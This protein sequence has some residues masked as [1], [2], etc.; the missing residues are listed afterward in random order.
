MGHRRAMGFRYRPGSAMKKAEEWRSKA[1]L[2]G[3]TALLGAAVVVL[4]LVL[5]LSD[6]VWA[7]PGG[8]HTFSRS[9]RGS[10]GGSYGGW[11]G[12]GGGGGDIDFVF[13]L[14]RLLVWYP[15]I[16]VPVVVVAG[17]WYWFTRQQGRRRDWS[18][19]AHQAPGYHP[20]PAYLGRRVSPRKQLEQLRRQ[21]P[22]FSLVLFEDFVFA[23]YAR[24]HEAR[25]KG[26]LE[27]LSPYLAGN[28]RS[29]LETL[30]HNLKEVKNIVIGAMSYVQVSG[31]GGTASSVDVILQFESNYTEVL[32]GKFD[33][34]EQSW[35]AVERWEFSRHPNARS[36]PPERIRN[37]G[38]PSCGA[39]LESIRGNRCSFCNQV[40]DTGEFDWMVTGVALLGREQRGPQLTT[41]VVEQ[42]TTLPTVVAPGAQTRLDALAR[43]D[44]E[45][46][47]E[48]LEARIH[49]VFDTLQDAWSSREWTKAR[50]Y[51]SDSLFQM[52]QYWIET[53][54]KQGLRNVTENARI[55]R[56]E[57]ADV[58]SDRYFDA[59]TVRVHATGLDYTVTDDGKLV[60]G[61]K[62]RPRA[63]SEYWTLI[64]GSGT[65]GA[66][67][68][69]A[70]CPS[71]GAPVKVNMAGSCEY[72]SA[73][74]TSGE[75]D[76]VLSRIEQ[77]EA[78]QG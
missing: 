62:T 1:R 36:R 58:T 64:R 22:D 19:M 25:G 76:W 54:R 6:E 75:F 74:L 17:T 12:S 50:P 70:S 65:R 27:I 52:L 11:G 9:S 60:C 33:G 66:S 46:D 24:V 41:D 48:R 42:G 56:I 72:C 15:Q 47:W 16:G 53:Y 37:F 68:S 29:Q 40:V 34:K 45:F 63:Y 69:D 61:S 57:V 13:G 7:R 28:A 4:F 26:Q 71:C 67:R 55:T 30:S 35:Y 3:W 51:V 77:D 38:C 43:K 49:F 32:S 5:A 59:I 31:V 44:P 2:P 23:L 14:V 20:G 39:P 18:T 21:D 10:G 8:G 78:Y 73:R